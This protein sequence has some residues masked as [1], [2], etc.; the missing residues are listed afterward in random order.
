VPCLVIS[1]GIDQ[2]EQPTHLGGHGLGL[3]ESIIIYVGRRKVHQRGGLRRKVAEVCGDARCF[4]ELI[5]CLWLPLASLH[6]GPISQG[7]LPHNPVVGALSDGQAGLE[8]F[9]RR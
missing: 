9:D 7:L 4:S 3:F 1:R 8:A 6:L 2:F 5:E